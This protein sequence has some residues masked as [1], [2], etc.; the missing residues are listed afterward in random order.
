MRKLNLLRLRARATELAALGLERF[1]AGYIFW[2][3]NAEPGPWRI[4][5]VFGADIPEI[6]PYIIFMP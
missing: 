2:K 3:I 1:E 4:F 5:Y 6:L